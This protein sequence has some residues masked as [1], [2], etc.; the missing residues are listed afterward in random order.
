MR[1]TNK[2]RRYVSAAPEPVGQGGEDL[3]K[4]LRWDSGRNAPHFSSGNLMVHGLCNHKYHHQLDWNSITF[5]ALVPTTPGLHHTAIYPTTASMETT[6]RLT[7]EAA[8]VSF[9]RHGRKLDTTWSAGGHF[10]SPWLDED[11]FDGDGLR[12]EQK[13]A[14]LSLEYADVLGCRLDLTGDLDGLEVEL[15][16]RVYRESAIVV[17]DACLHGRITAESPDFR[18]V[19]AYGIPDYTGPWGLVP[20]PSKAVG[21]CYSLFTNIGQDD[22]TSRSIPGPNGATY[23]VRGKA[24]R[25]IWILFAAGFE[26]AEV[27]SAMAD[28][29][30]GLDC[31]LERAAESFRDF[32]RRD[33]PPLSCSDASVERVYAEML[34]ACRLSVF[35]VPY[36]PYRYPFSVPAAKTFAEW[37]SQFGHDS[38]FASRTFL[39]LNDPE[40]CKHD[41]L[42]MLDVQFIHPNAGFGKPLHDPAAI[43]SP[44]LSFQAT[45]GWEAYC[46]T[47]DREL[48]RTV[49]RRFL[50]FDRRKCRPLPEG[51]TPPLN[52]EDPP[53]SFM[54]PHQHFDT[55]R[56][57]LVTSVLSGDDTCRADPFIEGTRPK[58]YY[59]G[60]K[61]PIEPADSNLYLLGN[62]LAMR[63][64]AEALGEQAVGRELDE[65]IAQHRA[66]M[67]RVMWVESE[68]RYAD[69]RE[70]DHFVSTV[71]EVGN[72][73]PALAY[74]LVSQ[75]RAERLIADLLNPETFWTPLPCPSCPVNHAG[76][77]GK[78]GFEP[79]GYWRGRTWPL[80][81][82]EAVQGLYRYGRKDHAAFLLHLFL[83]TLASAPQPAPENFNPLDRTCPGM[84]FM[85]FCTQFLNP[86]LALITGLQMAP[87]DDLLFDPV[88]LDPD[89]DRFHFGPFLYRPDVTIEVDW[90]PATGYAVTVNR[91]S[92]RFPVP[93]RFSLRRAADDSYR[94]DEAGVAP[95]RFAGRPPVTV[96][97]VVD[98]AGAV[99]VTLTNR[100]A[101]P[102]R[103]NVAHRLLVINQGLLLLPEKT[104]ALGP[105][106]TLTYAPEVPATGKTGDWV[107][108]AMT[109]DGYPVTVPEGVMLQTRKLA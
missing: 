86:M 54:F 36:D 13:I 92:W 39:W 69:V 12:V 44:Q 109:I 38:L 16:G 17:E 74:G 65:A 85:S 102:A 25:T 9:F 18:F 51:V 3:L 43:F 96:A 31:F 26:E 82:S 53:F 70:A 107:L 2:R 46:R 98:A 32:F 22:A 64:M 66:A 42:Q 1:L 87:G 76:I 47:G 8:D 63:R 7:D 78:P 24:T 106:E 40:R 68:G 27:R 60:T 41:L 4:H 56:D 77:N 84:M 72:I 97:C 105:N 33:V 5:R 35:D 89:W 88:G 62:R 81:V 20:A 94:L 23:R 103:G 75:D 79:Y 101:L 14:I 21:T 58:F 108:T 34:T 55:D 52:K 50:D 61:A 95:L 30:A 19:S 104:F 48:I 37:H 83:Q 10:W 91:Q 73:T 80:F 28:A 67:D 93:T 71:R 15:T 6:D 100:T 45:V 99:Q 29:R 90:S 59:E 57:W 11:M 49:L